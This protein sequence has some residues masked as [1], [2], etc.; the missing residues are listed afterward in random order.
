MGVRPVKAQAVLFYSQHP[1]G[2]LD[3][4][5]MHGGC[6]VLKVGDKGG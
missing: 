6:P 3:R 4:Q 1:N 5:S 2:A